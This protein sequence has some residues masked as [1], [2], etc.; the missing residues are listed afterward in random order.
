MYESATVQRTAEVT[1]NRWLLIFNHIWLFPSSSMRY[2]IRLSF[3]PTNRHLIPNNYLY[4]LLYSI[5]LGIL[6]HFLLQYFISISLTYHSFRSISIFTFVYY[7]CIHICHN[8]HDIGHFSGIGS[9]TVGHR[10]K[11][12]HQACQKMTITKSYCW[13][14]IFN[15][16]VF[17]F[18]PPPIV[19]F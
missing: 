2:K 7:L 16:H 3:N 11:I 10:D 19:Y 1:P 14:H 5:N 18:S 12:D 8:V 15:V 4:I 6:L 13:P 9:F 17:F